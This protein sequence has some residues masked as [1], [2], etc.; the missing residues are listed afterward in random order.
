M[1]ELVSVIGDCTL[2][3]RRN[4]FAVL[5]DSIISQ[6][7]SVHVAR[8]LFGRFQALFPNRRPNPQRVLHLTEDTFRAVGISRQKVGY[9]KD[10]AK[11]F[12]EG[13]IVSH[14]LWR[15]RDEDIVN[16]LV[17]VRGIGRWTAEMFLIFSLNREDVLP[18][19]DLGIQ[20]AIQRWYGLHDFPGPEQILEIGSHWK[21]YRTIASWYLW[22]SLHESFEKVGLP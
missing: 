18:T 6:Q 20:K 10:L 7:I 5:C 19:G 1:R 16:D 2:T 3:P 13:R 15:Q 4:Y 12:M 17:S 22:A 14:R 11:G 9:L 21:P 8:V